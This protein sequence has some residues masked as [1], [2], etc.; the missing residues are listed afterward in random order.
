MSE[1]RLRLTAQQHAALRNHL[2]PGDGKEAVALALCGRT[3]ALGSEVLLVHELELVPHEA[4]ARKPDRVEWPPTLVEHLFHK[5]AAKDLAILKVHSH[6]TGHYGF[7]RTDDHS[8]RT[9]FESVYGWVDGDRPHASAFMLPDGRMQARAVLVGGAFA[10]VHHVEVVGDDIIVWSS[11]HLP[12][13]PAFAERH[14]QLFGAATTTLLGR[15]RIAVVG[16]SGTGSPVIEQLV[17]LG[18]GEL[19][20][21]DPDHVEERN[22]NRILGATMEDAREGRLKVDVLQRHI[23]RIGLG[24]RVHTCP[25]SLAQPKAMRAVAASDLV[26]GCMDGLSGRHMLSRVARYYLLPYVDVGVKLEALENGTINQVAGTIHYLQ[27]TGSDFVDRGAF[28]LEALEAED[29]LRTSPEEYRER[30]ARGYVRGVPVDR[31]AVI[32]VNMLFASLAVNEVLARLHPFRMDANEEFATT[33]LS[34]S[35]A[36]IEHEQ[37]RLA[38]PRVLESVGRGDIEPLLE[39]PSLGVGDSRP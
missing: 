8:D 1:I 3:A 30:Y 7:S 17:R 35:H 9:L 24:T 18:V 13:V 36:Q 29:L 28:T 26:I 33:R 39:M 27:P 14:A 21:V 11:Q 19:V 32:S 22:L 37:D 23:E 25:C 12:A 20:L 6:A 31:P 5:A 15:L 34:L 4:C 10:P 2:F 16:C 38:P